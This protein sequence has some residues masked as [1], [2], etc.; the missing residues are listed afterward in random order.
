MHGWEDF[1]EIG[2]GGVT[3][4]CTFKVESSV[5]LLWWRWWTFEF[6]N[7]KNFLGKVITALLLK[8]E[9]C[10]VVQFIYLHLFE[11]S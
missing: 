2:Y 4:F 3:E 5:G 8:K 9:K 7:T 10:N 1:K 11:N 6:H